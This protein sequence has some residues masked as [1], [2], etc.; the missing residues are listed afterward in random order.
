MALF[1]PLVFSGASFPTEVPWPDSITLE[2]H[3]AEQTP[4]LSAVLRGYRVWGNGYT[5]CGTL[6]VKLVSNPEENNLEDEAK[7]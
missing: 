7:G 6:S 2:R 5:L 4:N 1:V 3:Q